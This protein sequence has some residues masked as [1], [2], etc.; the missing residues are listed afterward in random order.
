VNYEK[1]TGY[2]GELSGFRL[3]G[4]YRIRAAVV[5]AGIDYDDFRREVSRDGTAKKYWAG[6]NYEINRMIA[7]AFKVENNVNYNFSHAYQGFASINV[8][9]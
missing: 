1:R 8:S 6:V 4:G 5:S 3:Y 9:Y 7:A 2:A